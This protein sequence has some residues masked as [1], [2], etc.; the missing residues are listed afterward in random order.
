MSRDW[1]SI[2][3][4]EVERAGYQF[5]DRDIRMSGKKQFVL[6]PRHRINGRVVI[7]QDSFCPKG[8][9]IVSGNLLKKKNVKT[10]VFDRG[11]PQ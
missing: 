3:V 8:R 9:E 1:V 4:E 2:V 7:T 5:L 11:K 6:S 10:L